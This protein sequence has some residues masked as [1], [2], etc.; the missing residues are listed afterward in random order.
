MFS[1][2]IS[3][4]H[5]NFLFMGDQLIGFVKL[6]HKFM[7]DRYNLPDFDPWV[8]K[9]AWFTHCESSRP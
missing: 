4:T 8:L 7:G 1:L 5:T 3:L 2:P 6:M 9:A